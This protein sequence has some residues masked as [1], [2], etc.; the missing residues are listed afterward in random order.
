MQLVLKP[1]SFNSKKN[2]FF[3]YPLLE[4]IKLNENQRYKK[5]RTC[6]KE[7]FIQIEESTFVFEAYWK[8]LI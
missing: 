4:S 2:A 3:F 7:N 6:V 5:D 8:E 1:N